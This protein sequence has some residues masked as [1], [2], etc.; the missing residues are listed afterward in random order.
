ETALFDTGRPILVAPPKPPRVMGEN[1]VIAWNGSTETSRTIALGLPFLVK[2]AKV[3][4][5]TIENGLLPGPTGAEVVRHLLPHGIVAENVVRG[6]NGRPIG[7][8]IM[9]EVVKLDCDLLVKG[10]Y[11]QG[12]LRQLIFGGA[13]SHILA[14]AELP[15]LM[16]H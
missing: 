1:V 7:E 4:V 13:T 16:A 2:A 11:T 14:H 12:R 6:L 10:G 3:F 15:V 9:E 5:L 8:A